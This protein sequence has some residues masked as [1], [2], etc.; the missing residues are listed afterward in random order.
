MVVVLEQE[1]KSHIV[2]FLIIKITHS[3]LSYSYS[4]SS[5]VISYL[6]ISV[7]KSHYNLTYTILSY[8]YSQ[9]TIKLMNEGPS[10][11]K[12]RF[13]T[14]QTSGSNLDITCGSVIVSLIYY[15]IDNIFLYGL[16]ESGKLDCNIYT[17]YP[18]SILILIYPITLIFYT[19]D[20][21]T[22]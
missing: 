20:Y 8:S 19:K 14:G 21:F 10:N 1:D 3:S 6:Y 22:I 17:C 9:S 5:S 18:F 7:S 15:Y 2:D 12:N 4:S 16:V 13:Y 11:S